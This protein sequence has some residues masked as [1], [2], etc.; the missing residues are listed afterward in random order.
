MK[1]ISDIDFRKWLKVMKSKMNSMYTNQVW[2]LINLPEGIKLIESKLVLKRKTDMDGNVQTYKLT[3]CQML[4]IKTD[5]L[6]LMKLSFH[7]YVK[8][9]KDFTCYSCIPWF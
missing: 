6:T 3:S 8:I 7:K 1:P 9:H 2:T 4:Q 5:R